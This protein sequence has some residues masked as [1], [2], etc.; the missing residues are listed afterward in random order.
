MAR[1]RSSSHALVPPG[2]LST[3]LKGGAER[4][5]RFDRVRAAMEADPVFRVDDYYF[6]AREER[7]AERNLRVCVCACVCVCVEEKGGRERREKREKKKRG[8]LEEE[9]ERERKEDSGCVLR[10]RTLTD[11]EGF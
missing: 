8:G 3:Y 6:A 7:Y 9:I 1:E 10:V 11:A 4:K 2:P 5:A